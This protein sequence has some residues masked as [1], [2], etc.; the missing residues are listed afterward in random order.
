[1]MIKNTHLSSL[2]TRTKQGMTNSSAFSL[3]KNDKYANEKIEVIDLKGHQQLLQELMINQQ[4][5]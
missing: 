5:N 4:L 3:I 1:M 2:E